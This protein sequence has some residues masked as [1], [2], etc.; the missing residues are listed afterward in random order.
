MVVI[1]AMTV[2]DNIC[3]DDVVT[4]TIPE[5]HFLL[6]VIVMAIVKIMMLIVMA[7]VIAMVMAMVLVTMMMLIVT[8]YDADNN[9]DYI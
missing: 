3:C 5:L 6:E 8:L 4:M 9:G 1:V 7:M 2:Y